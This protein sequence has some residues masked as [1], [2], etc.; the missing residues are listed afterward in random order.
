MKKLNTTKAGNI[1][2]ECTPKIKL[3][4]DVQGIKNEQGQIEYNLDQL[5]IIACQ[6]IDFENALNF[7]EWIKLELPTDIVMSYIEN[8]PHHRIE[9]L[10]LI[11]SRFDKIFN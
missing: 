11:K 2:A 8:N 4:L 9:M 10:K 1:K 5:N 3:M 6:C 7:A